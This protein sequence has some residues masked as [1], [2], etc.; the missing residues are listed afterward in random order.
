MRGLSQTAVL[1]TLFLIPMYI[2]R[3]YIDLHFYVIIRT[4]IIVER[5]IFLS[6][7]IDLSGLL[8]NTIFSAVRKTVLQQFFF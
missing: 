1:K 6:K 2:S 7:I 5:I 4:I 8:F 3:K